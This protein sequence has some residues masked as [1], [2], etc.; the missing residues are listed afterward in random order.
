[1]QEMRTDIPVNE[2]ARIIMAMNRQEIETLVMLLT[3]EGNE[4]LE[5]KR[6]IESGKVKLLFGEE[7]FDV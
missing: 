5:R 4:L 1:M 3:E 2:V 6:D 7:V